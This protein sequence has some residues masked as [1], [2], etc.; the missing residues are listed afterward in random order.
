MQ[1]ISSGSVQIFYPKFNKE[2]IIQAIQKKLKHLTDSLPISTVLLFGS[3]AKGNYTVAS[4]IDILV[5]YKGK[6]RRDAYATVKRIL[7]IP[8]LEPHLYTKREYKEAKE[9]IDRMTKDSILLF[10]A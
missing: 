4:D 9:T 8:C 3:Y 6:E 5:V 2:E 10:Q 7:D 1:K